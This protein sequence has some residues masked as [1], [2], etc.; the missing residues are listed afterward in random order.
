M[1]DFK[2]ITVSPSYIKETL[3]KKEASTEETML[4]NRK[5]CGYLGYQPYLYVDGYVSLFYTDER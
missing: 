3:V 4:S 2:N 5:I 1:V